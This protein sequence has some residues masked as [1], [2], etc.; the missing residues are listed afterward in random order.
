MKRNFIKASAVALSFILFFVTIGPVY[1]DASRPSVNVSEVDTLKEQN[2][3]ISLTDNHQID[4]IEVQPMGIKTQLVKTALKY[5]GTTLGKLIKKIPFK[6]A[7]NVGS[8]IENWGFK[9]A[10]VVDELTSF[11]E[12]SVTLAL[13]KAGIP[14]SD[15]ILIAKF[16]VFFLG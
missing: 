12:A 10:G 11:G 4:N 14:P 9:A 2:N 6:W 13:V 16:I 1:A 3:S 8:S 7:K 5:G 15:A